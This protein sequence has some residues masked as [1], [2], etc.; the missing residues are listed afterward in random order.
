MNGKRQLVLI[1]HTK[2]SWG[3]VTLPDFDRP[4]KKDRVGDAIAM[5][6]RLKDLK[7]KPDLIICSPAKRTRQTATYFCDKWKYDE[8]K[9]AFD[10]R[11]YELGAEDIMQVVRE[12]DEAVKTLVVIGH[13][14]SITHFANEF[15]E[16]KI[17][18]IPT[19]GVVWIEFKSPDWQIYRATPAKLLAF[20][21]PKTI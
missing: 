20:L 11:I 4:L 7:I 19:T 3:D 13:N 10:K 12:T 5:A 8:K 15:L 16:E 6:A 9:V 18:E 2:S 17:D 1:R 14:P 21:T